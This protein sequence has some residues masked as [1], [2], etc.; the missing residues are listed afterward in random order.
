MKLFST[1]VLILVLGL[2][3]IGCNTVGEVFPPNDQVLVYPLPYDLTYLRTLET[4]EDYPDWQVSETDKE[5]GLIRV[6]DINYSRLDD[7][8]L[9]SVAFTVKRVDR[10]TTSVS[11][12]P[13]SQKVFGGDKL[14]QAVA[15]TLSGEIKS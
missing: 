5:K 10:G 14:L 8:D 9:R 11:I 13:E 6:R 2:G 12:A 3:L 1:I 7:S 15:A 4:L